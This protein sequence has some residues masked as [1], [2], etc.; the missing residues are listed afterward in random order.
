[1]RFIRLIIIVVIGAAA[2]SC[3]Q[4]GY[5]SM[6]YPGQEGQYTLQRVPESSAVAAPG[7]AAAQSPPPSPSPVVE[8]HADETS[9]TPSDADMATIRELWPKLSPSDRAALVDM[10]RHLAAGK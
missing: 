3:T 7:P 4:P 2:S 5:R 10:T 1:M 6:V 9:P 8:S